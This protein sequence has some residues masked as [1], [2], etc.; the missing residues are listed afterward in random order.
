MKI[1]I[2]TIATSIFIFLAMIYAF[3]QKFTSWGSTENETSMIIPEAKFLTNKRVLDTHAI[4]I[5]APVQIVWS[6]LIQLGQNRGGFYSYRWLEN[7]VGCKMPK[8]ETIDPRYQHLTVGEKILLHPKAPPLAVTVLAKNRALA[9][10][11]WFLLLES[12]GSYETR[13]LTRSYSWRDPAR[14]FNLADWI[15]GGAL[16]DF[17]HFIMERKMLLTIKK[18]SEK[19]SVK[20]IV[21]SMYPA[22]DRRFNA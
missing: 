19:T 15:L 11:G 16:F 1:L 18:L 9:F 10:E 2:L 14:P 5:Y 8:V 21:E 12:R 6:Y 17:V 7:L 13:L 22:P 4:T 20:L 3:R